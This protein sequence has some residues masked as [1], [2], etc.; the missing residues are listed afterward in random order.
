METFLSLVGVAAF[1]T[2]IVGL[3]VMVWRTGQPKEKVLSVDL[4]KR[5]ITVAVEPWMRELDR[6][7]KRAIPYISRLTLNESHP[8]W[9]RYSTLDLI[10]EA[11]RIRREQ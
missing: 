7:S 3:V 9:W 4:G 6:K 2:L 1:V 10:E 5:I 8:H 11:E